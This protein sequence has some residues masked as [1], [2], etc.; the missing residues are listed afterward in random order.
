M[1]NCSRASNQPWNQCPRQ[2]RRDAEL[3]LLWGVCVASHALVL[4]FTRT[5]TNIHH[6][7]SYINIHTFYW[8]IKSLIS[9]DIV[10]HIVWLRV[11]NERHSYLRKNGI[12][13]GKES[14]TAWVQ[15]A[16]LNW[17]VHLWYTGILRVRINN[18]VS[19]HRTLTPTR[20]RRRAPFRETNNLVFKGMSSCLVM[21]VW[22]QLV[23]CIL[24]YEVC[25]A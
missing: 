25:I 21:F 15:T 7:P 17:H 16:S 14:C 5:S 13:K 10:L 9:N 6:T 19:A 1:P 4:Q 24:V 23:Q 2:T 3:V 8:I 20:T 11:W 22:M 18:V 12:H